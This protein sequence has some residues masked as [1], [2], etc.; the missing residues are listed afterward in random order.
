MEEVQTVP[1]DLCHGGSFI[2]RSPC[3]PSDLPV[4]HEEAV[5][6]DTDFL[7]DGYMV[8]KGNS[9]SRSHQALT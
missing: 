9:S 1:L 3:D 4:L 7:L 6:P 8:L 5:V 2:G